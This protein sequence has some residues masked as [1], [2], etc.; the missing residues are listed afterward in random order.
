MMPASLPAF[1]YDRRLALGIAALLA[2]MPWPVSAKPPREWG[3][4]STDLALM[5][6]HNF[7]SC[8][9]DRTPR[10]PEALLALEPGTPAYTAKLQALAKGHNYCAVASDIRFNG[11]LF[12]GALAERLLANSPPAGGL[13]AALAYDASKPE[14]KARTPVEYT[15]LCLARHSPGDVDALLKTDPASPEENAALGKLVA[16]LPECVQAGQ[17]MRVNGPGLRA[18]IA[19]AAYRIVKLNDAGTPA[20][21][22]L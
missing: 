5:A 2:A 13:T 16:A 19:L 14:I 17:E 20:A 21:K 11:Q 10:G 3:S 1:R 4:K 9:V 6:M 22:G 18:M 7:G 12:V 15:G 8:V